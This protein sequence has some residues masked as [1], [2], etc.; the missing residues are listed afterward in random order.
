MSSCFCSSRLKIRISR[1]S[2][3]RK[4]LSTALPKDPVPPVISN[5]L[6]ENTSLFAAS[7]PVVIHTP[8]QLRPWRRHVPSGCREAIRIQRAIDYQFIVGH[9]LNLFAIDIGD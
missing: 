6:S 4:R 8:D 7:L 2:V 1:T 3:A 9:D 5:T